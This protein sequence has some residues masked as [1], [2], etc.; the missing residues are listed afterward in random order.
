MVTGRPSTVVD[1]STVPTSRST[2]GAKR[3]VAN[4]AE[5]AAI[6]AA[7]ADDRNF[8]KKGV[9]WA[10]RRIGRR[11]AALHAAAVAL[12]RRLTESPEA[13]ARWVGKD[14]LKDLTSPAVTGRLA[15]GSAG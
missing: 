3:Y 12:A 4:P 9:S 2:L 13:A 6:V 1:V 14:A 10:L 8:V 15:S 5:L 11:N 7:A